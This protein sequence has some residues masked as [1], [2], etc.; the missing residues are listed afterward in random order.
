MSISAAQP[1]VPS[2]WTSEIHT[3]RYFLRCISLGAGRT[4]SRSSYSFS[5]SGIAKSVRA[6]TAARSQIGPIARDQ[7]QFNV[8]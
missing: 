8:T 4:R 7:C 2:R 1:R 6:F 3:V 5:S